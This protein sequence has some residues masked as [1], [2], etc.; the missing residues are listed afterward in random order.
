MQD[1]IEATEPRYKIESEGTCPSY[2]GDFRAAVSNLAM[3]IGL[4]YKE[5][6]VTVLNGDNGDDFQPLEV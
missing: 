1:E 2:R 6:R 3:R 5:T 4:G